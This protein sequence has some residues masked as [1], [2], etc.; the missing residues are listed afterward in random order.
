MTISK[1]TSPASTLRIPPVNALEAFEA[2]ARLGSFSK[3]SVELSVSQS[4]ISHRISQL[5]WLLGGP[6]FVRVAQSVS[7]TAQGEA[8]LPH[9]KQGLHHL[10]NG[11]AAFGGVQHKTIRLSIAPALASNWLVHRLGAFQRMHPDIVVDIIVTSKMSNLKAGEADVGLRF[12]TGNWEGL[13]AIELVPVRILAVCSPEYK[14]AHLSLRE[15]GDLSQATL[16]RQT[17]VPW[18]P[19]FESVGLDW[20]EPKTGPSFSEVSLLIDAAE[21]SQGVALVL[22]ALVERQLE[23]GSLVK[24]FDIERT[25]DRSYYI[26]TPR[27]E[28]RGAEVD[29]LVDWLRTSTG[30]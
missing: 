25:S 5:E 1:Q 19:W 7:L 28:P 21:C 8:F 30:R 4:A 13:D 27:G 9:V 6:L 11:I 10:R 26:V 12:G 24:L 22:S 15:P 18:K 29:A 23:S 3:A 2:V 20:P 16:L 17:I 14:R